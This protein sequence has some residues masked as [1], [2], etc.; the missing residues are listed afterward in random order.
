MIKNN[1]KYY[2]AIDDKNFY[3][4]LFTKKEFYKTFIHKSTETNEEF[5]D[6][7]CNPTSFRPMPQQD[8]LRN[9]ISINTPYNGILIFHG[10]GAGKT[11]AAVLITEGF[12]KIMKNFRKKILVLAGNRLIENF[13]NTLFNMKRQINKKKKDDIVQCTGK[14]YELTDEDK[15]LTTEQKTRK[16]RNNILKN[17]KLMGYLK[18]ANY[19]KI[20]TNW[21]GKLK[22]ITDKVKKI[23]H[24][25]FSNRIIVIDEVHNIKSK[26]G[27]KETQKTVPPILE[28]VI[29]YSEN[30]RLIF[31]SATPMHDN[32]NEIIYLLNL[33][34]LN[35]NREIINEKEIFEK[36]ESGNEYLTD[37][38]KKILEE[39]AKGYISFFK[40]SNPISFPVRINPE[41][42]IIPKYKYDIAGNKINENEMIKYTEIYP[43][44]MSK[45]QYNCYQETIKKYKDKI[46]NKSGGI[47]D[48]VTQISNIVYPTKRSFT[49]G[50]KGYTQSNDGNGAFYKQ[51]KKI[52]GTNKTI[53]IFKYQSHVIENIDTKDEK[54]FL[55]ISQ[56]GKYSTKL[57]N[58]LKNVLTA[59]GPIFIY[60]SYKAAGVLP[61]ALMLEQNG[62]ER[63]TI[64]GESQLLNYPFNKK[65]GGGKSEAISYLNGLPISNKKCK[66]HKIAKYLLITGDTDISKISKDP[67]H[68]TNIFNSASNKD[69][70]EIKVIIGTKVISEG[71]DFKNIRQVHI[72]EPW[73]NFSTNEQTI[74]RAL[75]NCSHVSLPPEE[76]NVEI[77]QYASLPYKKSKKKNRDTE[78]IDE[79]KYRFS[80]EKDRRIKDVE[81]VLKRV[82]VDCN[83]FKNANIFNKNLYIN[84]ITASHRKLKINLNEKPYSRE[85][86][87][88]KECNY[89]CIWKP[90]KKFEINKDTYNI[91]YAKTDIDDSKKI[92]RYLFK[93]KWVYKLEEIIENIKKD[94]PYIEN[95]FIY[96]ALDELLCN[97]NENLED[98]YNRDGKII[99]R[100]NYYIFQPNSIKYQNIPIYY[101]TKPLTVKPKYIEILNLVGNI[102]TDKKESS[103]KSKETKIEETFLKCVNNLIKIWSKYFD[104][105]NNLLELFNEYQL[106]R[107]NKKDVVK[108]FKYIHQNN[109]IDKIYENILNNKKYFNKNTFTYK[110]TLYTLD[111]Q[112]KVW[113]ESKINEN[114]IDYNDHEK[115]SEIYGILVKNKNNKYDMKI[116]DKSKN[117]NTITQTKKKSM[118]SIITGRACSTHRLTQ[119]VNLL[120]KLGYNLKV[121]NKKK[122]HLCILI[123]I[124]FRLNNSK[125][126]LIWFI[127]KT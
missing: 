40:G 65:G 77:Y 108:L 102:K 118:R 55:D 60:S 109:K 35:D 85:C 37:K 115:I 68:F 1:Y 6:R 117:K 70:S 114:I 13:I 27:T 67:T 125:N 10:T 21:D 32:P 94:I 119:L 76:R 11:C 72:L 28:A 100:G 63:Y 84:V 88:K 51:I 91:K 79:K 45:Y 16:I 57:H 124:I 110:D 5:L 93:I 66:N 112:T 44:Y 73:Y 71:I 8:F 92:I 98:K 61:I 120:E 41:Q 82:A 104:Y 64:E 18:F 34:L 126:K 123:E 116:I 20:K 42:N 122:P 7:V 106:D 69:G 54:P 17:Y 25:E 23:I 48:D 83:L 101:K 36:N 97:E 81:H 2:P 95:M 38:G 50:L 15:Y 9:Y 29:K 89:S 47:M 75:R 80:E 105:N 58:I 56:I 113:K 103:N 99:Y 62:F 78:T 46:D 96:K 53:P 31:L 30:K 24:D 52:P 87:Y 90:K 22:N 111:K 59:K 3:E 39:K 107:T 33:L 49:Y 127:N 86:D 12:K 19:V 121:I 43:C 14:E 74:G 4:N 26:A